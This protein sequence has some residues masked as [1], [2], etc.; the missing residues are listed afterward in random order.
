MNTTNIATRL[1][2]GAIVTALI[3]GFS[4]IA[5]AAEGSDSAQKTIK[6]T[7][8]SVSSAQGADTLYNRIR[9]ASEEVCSPLD[10]GDLSSKMH[11]KACMQK[12]IAD[13]VR[14]VNQPALTA[15]YNARNGGSLP[16]IAAAK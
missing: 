11:A 6:Y 4:S 1:I 7:D 16:M 5:S 12:S 10:H 15:V 2:A 3:G 9:S 8:V 13:A 14:Q